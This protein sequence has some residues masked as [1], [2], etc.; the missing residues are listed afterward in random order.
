MRLILASF[1]TA[2]AAGLCYHGPSQALLLPLIGIP[3]LAMALFALPLLFRRGQFASIGRGLTASL[4]LRWLSLAFLFWLATGLFWSAW[5]SLS[6]WYFLTVAWYPVGFLVLSSNKD[7]VLRLQ[8]WLFG[9][10]AVAVLFGL[11]EFFSTGE[12]VNSL[13]IDPNSF[14]ALINLLFFAALGELF[15]TIEA[16][17]YRMVLLSGLLA[18]LTATLVL[19]QS[20]G[21]WIAGMG[22]AVLAALVLCRYKADVGRN[23]LLIGLG[24]IGSGLLAGTLLLG[25]PHLL[26]RADSIGDYA[27]NGRWLIWQS[28]LKAIAENGYLG[29]G[30]GTFKLFYPQFRNPMEH[31]T[32]GNMAH[33]DYLQ[34]ALEIGLP[35]VMLF[36]AIGLTIAWLFI[37]HCYPGHRESGSHVNVRPRIAGLLGLV[38]VLTAH[39]HALVNFVFYET[40][41]TISAAVILALAVIRLQPP[42]DDRVSNASP[43]ARA[44]P[45]AIV[46]FAVLA[47]GLVTDSA[48]GHFLALGQK[49]VAT[50]KT[51]AG[52]RYDAA[53]FLSTFYPLNTRA[54]EYAMAAQFNAA[55]TSKI[56]SIKKTAEDLAIASA[57][58]L[59]TYKQRDCMAQTIVASFPTKSLQREGMLDALALQNA[60]AELKQ[61]T[62]QLPL[63]VPA[64]LQDADL[65]QYEGHRDEALEILLAATKR[66]STRDNDQSNRLLLLERAGKLAADIQRSKIATRMAL[67]ILQHQPHNEWAQ[68][69]LRSLRQ[70]GASLAP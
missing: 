1:I 7:A 41:I 48:I 47:V 16:Q 63:C 23:Q 3:L 64:Y 30:L 53:L 5:P 59:L 29:T 43:R 40:T 68:D 45:I 8:D 10:G 58:Q 54:T 57:N 46:C 21:G 42:P 67:S 28:T 37:R 15:L 61:T 44:N 33:N 32:T 22:G 60:K 39:A 31:G 35:G 2:L 55:E 49:N 50:P 56:P 4:L 11:I 14:A 66:F 9:L 51:L 18:A 25:V 17:R 13:F 52:P 12:R 36:L 19:T 70:Q 34:F 26:G 27:G 24:S 62:Q 6:Y 65:L 20:R 38:G 69:Y